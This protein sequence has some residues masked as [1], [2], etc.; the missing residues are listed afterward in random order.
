MEKDIRWGW[1]VSW[2]FFTAALIL[3]GI[4]LVTWQHNVVYTGIIAGWIISPVSHWACRKGYQQKC[5]SVERH[6][7]LIANIHKFHRY[8]L[9]GTWA[10]L[11]AISPLFALGLT[12]L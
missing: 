11:I 12:D 2:S 6:T 9:F 5:R 10:G 8:R 3:I 4:Q 1:V 7:Y